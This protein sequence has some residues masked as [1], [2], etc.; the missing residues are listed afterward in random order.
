MKAAVYYENGGPEVLRY[1]DVPDPACPPD[2]VVIEV[3]VVS[4]EGGDTLHRAGTPPAHR[5][6]VVGYQCAGTIR[7][8]GREVKDRRVGERV[9]AIMPSG[10]HAERAAAAASS[11]WPVPAGADLESIACV[12]VAFGTA[13]EALFAHAH[14]ARGER[15]LVHAGGGGVG[16][17]AIQLAR[18]AG[19]EVVTTASSDEKLARLREL[20]AAHTVNYRTTPLVEGVARAVGRD[21]IDV[22]VDGVGGRTLQESVECLRYRGRIVSLGRAGRDPTPFQPMPLWRK[23][24]ALI[25]LYLLAS[26]QHE[27]ARVHGVIDECIRRVAAGELRVVIAAR[28]PLSHAAAAHAHVEGRSAFGRVILLPRG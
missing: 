10:S 5:P 2:G 12:P 16:M 7:E 11:V 27:W 28:Y 3:E 8:V 22:V 13:H 25:G 26:L 23:N 15:V 24:G 19:A 4:L 20:G 14:L 17:A 6:H 1:E 18:S 9:V 21:G